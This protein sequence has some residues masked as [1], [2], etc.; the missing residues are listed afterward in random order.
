MLQGK[1]AIYSDRASRY[2]TNE[3]VGW[4]ENMGHLNDGPTLR[5][6][7]RLLNKGL[8]TKEALEKFQGTIEEH[9]R[10]FLR[11]LVEDTTP[12][13]ATITHHVRRCGPI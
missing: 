11:R 8:G 5:E 7:R 13:G 9:T 6:R 4:K 12:G 2:F 3:L 1:G 10:A